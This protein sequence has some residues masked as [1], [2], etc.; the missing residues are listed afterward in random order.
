MI[1]WKEKLSSR[2]FWAAV[3]EFVTMLMIAF[4]FD[5]STVTQVSAVI[6]AGGGL[7]AWIVAEG[8]VDAAR[9]GAAKPPDTEPEKITE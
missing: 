7:I 2:K 8:L 9:V 5:E 1:N 3:A 6:M 4:K